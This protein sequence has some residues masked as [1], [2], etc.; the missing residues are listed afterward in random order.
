[1]KLNQKGIQLIKTFEGCLLNAYL[2]SGNVW[3]IGYG[4][5]FY[6]DGTKVK[7]GDKITQQQADELLTFHGAKFAEGVAKLITKD[8][9]DNQFSALVS[10]AFNLGIGA[11]QKSTL[12]KKVN[13]NPND[14]TIEFEFGKWVNANGKRLTGLVRRRQAEWLL[15]STK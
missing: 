13:A 9:T 5:T 6:K 8:L 3:T 11:L 15:Y 14:M 7:Q 2:C 1:M 12:L 4:A 10:F